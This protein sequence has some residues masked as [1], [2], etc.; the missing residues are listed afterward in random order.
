MSEARKSWVSARS[1]MACS[2]LRT[3]ASRF[4]VAMSRFRYRKPSLEGVD[5][6][7]EQPTLVLG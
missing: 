6:R 7:M 2:I 3:D 1:G 5:S 4:P